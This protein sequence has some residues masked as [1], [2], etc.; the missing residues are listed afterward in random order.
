MFTQNQVRQFYVANSYQDNVTGLTNAGDVMVQSQGKD[1]YFN[2]VNADGEVMRSDLIDINKI[3]SITFTPAEKMQ[4]KSKATVV[5]LNANVNSGAIVAGQDYMLN[6]RINQMYWNSDQ[7]WGWKYGVVHGTTG[8]STSDFYKKMALSL[9][10]NMSREATP[11]LKVYIATSDIADDADITTGNTREVKATDT[12]AT[13]PTGTTYAVIVDEAEQPWR[14]FQMQQAPVYYEAK[15]DNIVVDNDEVKWGV[16]KT[17]T[18][19]TT[20]ENGKKI[21]DMEYFYHGERGDIYRES[22]WPNNWKNEMIANKNNKYDTIDIHYYWNGANHA[23]QKSEKDITLACVATTGT[24]TDEVI[25]KIA[26]A[27]KTAGI[28]DIAP[29]SAVTE[30]VYTI[31]F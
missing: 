19:L 25:Y 17:K 1:L 14:L 30:N 12:E 13:L 5:K 31:E 10:A 15:S 6:I 8:M 22:A 3:K 4:Y 28:T 2:Y 24:S 26:D 9:V 18:G 27:M 29:A 16:E 7:T 11:I 23:V 21:C 20:I